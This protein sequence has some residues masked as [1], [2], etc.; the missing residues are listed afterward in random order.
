[1]KAGPRRSWQKNGE[2]YGERRQASFALK[3]VPDT[4][5]ALQASFTLKKVPDTFSALT[6]SA[7]TPFLFSAPGVPEKTAFSR[8]PTWPSHPAGG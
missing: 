6:F 3:K 2:K 4:F 8:R 1:M 5:S 7:L